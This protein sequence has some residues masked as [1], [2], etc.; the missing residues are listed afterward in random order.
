MRDVSETAYLVSLCRALETE[1]PKALFQDPFAR[2][3]AGGKG[4][5]QQKMLGDIRAIANAIAVRTYIIDEIIGQLIRVNGID[6]I[7]N[8]GAGLDT[9]PYRLNLPASL[10]WIEVDIPNIL[11]YKEQKLEQEQP[12]CA[13]ERVKL[14]LD[15]RTSRNTLFTKINDESQQVL[16]LAEGIL[17]YLTEAQ[18]ADLAMNL[19]Q[20]PNF[21][22]WM[23]DLT[24]QSLLEQLQHH[25]SQKIFRQYFTDGKTAF[26]FAPDNGTDFFRP[27][28]WQRS[29]FRSTWE[30]TRRLKRAHRCA[31]F[32]ELL[33]RWFGK[34]S[35]QE[36]RQ[37]SGIVLLTRTSFDLNEIN[38]SLGCQNELT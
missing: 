8:L 7:L 38:K 10:R 14:D 3:L 28:G 30:E 21:Y 9:R 4:A 19:Y 15:D 31:G 11:S 33:I 37:K 1:K 29:E 12:R 13:L 16:V 17:G 27:Y 6:T 35:W 22:W 5:L 23:F 2:S 24:A 32:Q 20:Q 18:V 26:S 34:E 36:F 25:Q